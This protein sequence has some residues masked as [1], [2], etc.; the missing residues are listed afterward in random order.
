MIGPKRCFKS[1]GVIFCCVSGGTHF[2]TYF[3]LF[4]T[5]CSRKWESHSLLSTCGRRAE[6]MSVWRRVLLIYIHTEGILLYIPNCNF[7]FNSKS[8]SIFFSYS[9]ICF[10]SIEKTELWKMAV[11]PV[12][13]QM[14]RFGWLL[15]EILAVSVSAWEVDEVDCIYELSGI[16]VIVEGGALPGLPL[17]LVSCYWYW[18]IWTCYTL[19]VIFLHGWFLW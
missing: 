18:P 3:R 14:E 9:I 6:N 4:K 11:R 12:P 5:S 16:P 10:F 8:W 7:V 2:G 17:V 19:I 1:K 13:E 15:Y